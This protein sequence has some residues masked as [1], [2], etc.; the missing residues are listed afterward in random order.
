MHLRRWAVTLC[1]VPVV[2]CQAAAEEDPPEPIAFEVVGEAPVIDL[3]EEGIP[4]LLPGA[5]VVHGGIVH[6][7]GVAFSADPA[8]EPRV[9]HLTSDDG[10]ATWEGDTTASVMEDFA[11]EL[12]VIGP[13]P[14]SAFV[15]DDGTWVMVGGGRLP[16]GERPIIWRAT[17]PGPD[18]PWTAHGVPVL[19]PSAD[20]WDTRIVDHPTIL[21][22]D[23]GELLLAYGGASAVTP[24]RN[25]IGFATSTDGVTWTRMSATLDGADD[26]DALG[27]DACGIDART[28]V[29]P[30]LLPHG[31]A[32]LLV[33]GL[34]AEGSDSD[35][36]ILIATSTDGRTWTCASGDDPLSAGD[37]PGGRN[38]H[39]LAVIADP[40]GPPSLLIEVLGE[41]HSTLWLAR[42]AVTSP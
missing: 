18:G 28:M 30:H 24:N 8:E 40:D 27:P 33:F 13:V 38:I 39:S 35:M 32:H 6:L 9:L 15:G 42:P 3:T 22:T 34:M 11:M 25:R 41:G 17:A 26:A 31:D 10:G 12:D 20:G 5:T 37:V 21:P 36:Q 29:E 19:E 7:Y 14:A 2:A 23:D 16:G 4:Y 1:F